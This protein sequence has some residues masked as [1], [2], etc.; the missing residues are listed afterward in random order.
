[1][2]SFAY[3]KTKLFFITPIPLRGSQHSLPQSNRCLRSIFGEDHQNGDNIERVRGNKRN[4]EGESWPA[5]TK[6]WPNSP[7]WPLYSKQLQAAVIT[8]RT[9]HWGFSLSAL[10]TVRSSR[11]VSLPVLL[12]L[13]DPSHYHSPPHI[14]HTPASNC[15]GHRPLCFRKMLFHSIRAHRWC[16]YGPLQLLASWDPVY[17]YHSENK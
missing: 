16:G 9:I 6:L 10:Y 5:S 15:L 11:W 8:A 13:L 2:N 17:H 14:N 1:M 12:L 3:L 7:G 4:A